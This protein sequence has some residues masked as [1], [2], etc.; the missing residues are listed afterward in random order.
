MNNLEFE[1]IKQIITTEDLHFENISSILSWI[2]INEK[3][4]NKQAEIREVLFYLLDRKSDIN[5]ELIPILYNFVERLGYYPYL[6]TPEN[7][8]NIRSLLHFEFYRSENIPHIVLHQKQAE[9]MN[10]L[11]ENKSVILSAPTSFGK[12]LIIEEIVAADIYKNITIILPTL[13]LIDEVRQ[14]LSKYN[15][16]YK[17][18]FT[19]K[20]SMGEKNI[21]ILT[22]EK[23]IELENM[24]TIDFFII[25]EFYK[26]SYQND[27]NERVNVLNHVFYNLMKQ[28][29][30]F[31]LLGPNIDSI[32]KDF[33]SRYGCD[34]FSTDFSTVATEEISIINNTSDKFE[35]LKVLLTSLE[36]PTLIYC[37]SPASAEKNAKMFLEIMRKVPT[38]QTNSHADAIEWIK[39]NIHLDWSLSKTLEYKIAFHHGVIPRYLGRYIIN[40]FNKGNIKYLFCTSTLIEGINTA[41]K[42]VVIYENKKGISKLTHF[43]YKNI[44][45]RAGRMKQY[46]VG[47]VFTFHEPPKKST[48]HVDFPWFTQDTSTDEVLIQMEYEDLSAKSKT[49]I[50]YYLDQD[51]L[52]LEVIKKNNN[53]NVA[54]QISLANELLGNIDYF[55]KFLSWDGLPTSAQLKVCCELIWK[56][57][58]KKG[59]DEIYTAKSLH[60]FLNT[61]RM[62]QQPVVSSFIRSILLNDNKITEPDE[63]VQKALKIIRKW[64]EFRFPKLLLGLE[65]I[66]KS[67]FLK[68]KKTYGDYK[69]FATSIESGF[70]NPTLSNLEEFGLPLSLLRKLELHLINIEEAD[71]DEIIKQIKNLDFTKIDLDRFEK[72][73]INEFILN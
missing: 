71:L 42:N 25:D 2:D 35:Q 50:Q 31:Y 72:R 20:Q 19:T 40:E 45:G 48:M 13:A 69:L 55:H 68:H 56:H 3:K 26:I 61:Y 54:G 66:Q 59:R 46:F 58:V 14:K 60:Y 57:F 41:A 10:K 39:K 15:N 33:E 73:L 38:M 1:K 22:P 30:K 36:E 5:K 29:K 37:Q 18:V 6:D 23:Y 32:P 8:M 24:P 7:E 21:F 4:S 11:S 9:V 47:N 27:D 28:T 17:L 44:S 64:F 34:F 70:L 63:A 53:L 52:P 51:V 49:K 43:D 65:Q 62:S 16:T 12:S 67:V